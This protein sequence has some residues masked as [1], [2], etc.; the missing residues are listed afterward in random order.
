MTRPTGSEAQ[1]IDASPTDAAGIAVQ[2]RLL[3]DRL[4]EDDIGG[5]MARLAA[6][7]I[8]PRRGGTVAKRLNPVER[9]NRFR[10]RQVV[11][12]QSP[13]KMMFRLVSYR[14]NQPA[15]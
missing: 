2:A 15:I 1:I 12:C 5:W 11:P 6:K 14:D 8:S 10:S 9:K 3:A 13:F 7:V 4:T